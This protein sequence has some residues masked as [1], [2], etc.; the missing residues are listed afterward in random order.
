[1]SAVALLALLVGM[2]IGGMSS[3]P[4]RPPLQA[5]VI[6]EDNNSGAFGST[7]YAVDAKGGIQYLDTRT[8]KGVWTSFKYSPESPR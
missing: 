5:M 4:D 7:L 3:A 6:D 1:M 8:G 2:G